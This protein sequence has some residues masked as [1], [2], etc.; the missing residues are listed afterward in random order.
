[1]TS[2]SKPS[3]LPLPHLPLRAV[4]IVPFVL[5]IFAAVGLVGYLSFKNGQESTDRLANQ[6][7]NEISDR[8]DQHLD[9]YLIQPTR[10]NQLNAHAVDSQ[11]LD[12]KD[13]KT[14]GRYLWQQMQVYSDFSYIFY[15]LPTKEY[16]GAGRW[17]EGHGTTIEEISAQTGYANIV[18]DADQQGN[19]TKVAYKTEY[20]PLEEYW[21]TQ[22]VKTKKPIWSKIYNWQ[23]TPQFISISASFPVYDKQNNVIGV[24]A[25][26][27]LLSNISEF[28]QKL[29]TSQT[30]KVFILERDGNIVASSSS[31][32]PFVLVENAAQ[33]L[34]AAKSSDPLIRA[35]AA[36]LQKEV[37]SLPSI[38]KEQAFDV[39]LDGEHYYA[40]VS[41]WKDEYGL[42]WLVVI[43]VPESDFMAQINAN[44]RTT[45]LLCLG[46]LGL[47]TLL[48]VYTSRWIARPILQLQQASEAIATGELDRTVTVKGINELE[49][50]GR[51]F[52][53]MAAQLKSAF[54]V[55]EDRVAERTVELQAAKEV[56]DNANQAKSEFLANMSHELRTPLNGILGYAQILQRSK[57]LPE[58]ERHGANII[59]DCGSHLLT[60]INDVLDLSKIEARKLELAPKSIHFPSFL[61]GVVEICRIRAEQKGIDFR[62]EPDADLPDGVAID[63]KR[64][65]QVLLNLMG[66]A[67]KFTD[68][69]SVTLRVEQVVKSDLDTTLRFTVADTGVGIDTQ[70]VNKLFQAFEQVGEQKRKAEGTGLGLALSQQIVQFM[71]GTIQV[72]SQPGV[73]SDFFFEMTLPIALNWT[74]QQMAAVGNVTGYEGAPQHILVVDD[75]WENRAVL[76]N[77]LEPLGFL[78]TEAENGQAGLD[79]M[80]ET[81]PDLV[82]TDLA[83]PVMD[84]FEMLRQL[85]ASETLRSLKV[86]V[87]SASVAQL[88]QQMSFDAGGDDFLGKPVQVNELFK[89]LE[90]HLDLTWKTEEAEI[91][92]VEKPAELVP[93]PSED[94]QALL[95]LVQEGRLKKFIELAEELGQHHDRSRSFIQSMVQLAKQFQS[96]SLEQFIQ[97]YLP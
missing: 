5:Q 74:E 89:L 14:T 64:L 86:I 69:G 59:Y 2:P 66:N 71:G 26:D 53:Q 70:D 4:L 6:L 27:L 50:L 37:G 3:G 56:A 18:Y 75:R 38:A 72:K 30:G 21:Y 17:L 12:L 97:T 36:T 49:G 80:L 29:K 67:I 63:E 68:E 91:Q 19:R 45:I 85:R 78:I 11:L 57:V 88:D 92:D 10:L 73:G 61:Q 43:A 15:A 76:L 87:S 22:A 55:L 79:K 16:L 44:T 32:K 82:I 90:K 34:S 84:G 42:D 8:V 46:A 33:R 77:L 60:L 23:D 25:S 81:L 51:S 47:A 20:A 48:G 95:E 13:L 62:Y 41:P 96:E 40:S 83:M 35:A 52:N 7:M 31:E 24:L 39:Q 9:S 1:M 65:R 28:L 93:L 58:K 94:L 54:T